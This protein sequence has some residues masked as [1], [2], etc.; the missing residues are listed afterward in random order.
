MSACVTYRLCHALRIGFVK[1]MGIACMSSPVD[2]SYIMVSYHKGVERV[3]DRQSMAGC[4]TSKPSCVHAVYVARSYNEYNEAI[5][6]V[7]LPTQP[8]VW[9]VCPGT[10][11]WHENSYRV[12]VWEYYSA[13]IISNKLCKKARNVECWLGQ[14]YMF[15]NN[16]IHYGK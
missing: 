6:T 13:H 5:A 15:N 9:K 7:E 10:C 12:R 2:T 11:P 3:C 8:I 4:H 14:L 16:T 1:F